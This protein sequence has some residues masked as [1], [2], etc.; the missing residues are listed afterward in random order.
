MLLELLNCLDFSFKCFSIEELR[1][2]PSAAAVPFHQR[3]MSVSMTKE[4][5][6]LQQQQQHHQH[7]NEWSPLQVASS[8]RLGLAP[9][10]AR[11]LLIQS[12]HHVGGGNSSSTSSSHSDIRPLLKQQMLPPELPLRRGGSVDRVLFPTEN[13]NTNTT[14]SSNSKKDGCL[15][16][17]F[18]SLL[19]FLHQFA[20]ILGE[21]GSFNPINNVLTFKV[22][23]PNPTQGVNMVKCQDSSTVEVM[24][25]LRIDEHY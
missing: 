18:T 20:I 11:P 22:Y 15:N 10:M 7:G 17:L 9:Q 24:T 19:M 4:Q 13:Y 23:G 25:Y 3:S 21:S 2:L 5:Q 8:T 12:H 14:K 6:Q 1:T 16:I